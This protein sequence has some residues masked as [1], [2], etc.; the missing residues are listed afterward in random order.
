[1]QDWKCLQLACYHPL[2]A[3]YTL[4]N[5]GKKQIH[6]F[7]KDIMND[8]NFW[9]RDKQDYSFL[10]NKLSDPSK[11]LLLPCGQCVGCRL[12]H[13][14]EWAVRCMLE[15]KEH[16]F[17]WFVTFTYDDEHLKPLLFNHPYEI[18]TNT[19]EVKKYQKYANLCP[20]DMTD[21]IKRLRMHWKRNHDWD[22]IK[23]F[24]CGEY[25][26]LNGRP[27]YHAI[28]FN[29]PIYDLK[30]SV[31]M[32]SRSG[33]G[34]LYE[35]ME[36]SSLWN[37]GIVAIGE[38]NFQTC[39]YTA[40]YILKKHK[41]ADREYYEQNGIVPEFVRMS[42]KPAIAKKYY[43]EHKDDIYKN[44]VFYMTDKDNKVF[45][46]KPPSYFDKLYD[47]DNPDVLQH[48][49]EV[50]KITAEKLKGQPLTDLNERQYLQVQENNK[51]FSA[52]SLTRSL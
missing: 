9:N 21:F 22:G 29:L 44:D 24:L 4:G 27:H 23:Y 5:D 43:D 26:S 45:A 25:G 11:F 17:N 51:L 31:L 39:A 48:L 41:G 18:D 14:R 19:G 28:I 42:L 7:N 46:C 50:R 13:S 32:K 33:K 30:K 35:S 52:K 8:F 38:V 1:M 12:D 20:K 15:A 37:K 2:P 49:K 34:L 47:V 10:K 16:Q 6:F 3:F 36:L 40:R